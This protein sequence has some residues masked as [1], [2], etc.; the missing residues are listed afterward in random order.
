MLTTGFIIHMLKHRN[1]HPFSRLVTMLVISSN[2]LEAVAN[3]SS[4]LLMPPAAEAGRV[5][6]VISGAFR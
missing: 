4:L 1:F 2:W 3:M 6:C 5:E